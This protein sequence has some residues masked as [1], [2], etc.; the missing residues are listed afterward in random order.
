[1][2]A[3]RREI[4]NGVEKN[5]AVNHLGHFLLVNGLLERLY[6][7]AQGRVVV[8]ASRTAYRGGTG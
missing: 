4:V 6:L 3:D 8:V 7:A 1:M 2:R 5:F